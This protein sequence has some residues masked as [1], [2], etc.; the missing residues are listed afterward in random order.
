M[1]ACEKE[2]FT[3]LQKRERLVLLL[4]C[5]CVCA[6]ITTTSSKREREE[7][8]AQVFFCNH[9]LFIIQKLFLF[10]SSPNP[11]SLPSAA[12]RRRVYF[13]FKVVLLLPLLFVRSKRRSASNAFYFLFKVCSSSPSSFS[14]GSVDGEGAGA[15]PKATSK[16][17]NFGVVSQENARGARFFLTASSV[18]TE[19]SS[20]SFCSRRPFNSNNAL[21]ASR[22]AFF[23]AS[24]KTPSPSKGRVPCR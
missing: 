1:N 21:I 13:L 23:C 2:I 4:Y 22:N 24:S 5:A 14:S 17:S 8:S 11:L 7:N 3:F 20:S 16:F 15:R 10:T 6:V 19:S 9:R 18:I 12:L